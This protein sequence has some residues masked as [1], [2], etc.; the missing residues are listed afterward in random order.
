MSSRAP[1]APHIPL[2][3]RAGEPLSFKITWTYLLLIASRV[4]E[5]LAL[6]TG[7]TLRLVLPTS[8]ATIAANVAN[9][10][11]MRSL[12]SPCGLLLSAFFMWMLVCVPFSIWRGGSVE[13]IRERWLIAYLTF[14]V[15]A[16]LPT[17]LQCRKLFNALVISELIMLGSIQLLGV[18]KQGRLSLNYGTL[19]NANDLAIHLLLGFP[20][21]YFFLLPGR[22][23]SM[24]LRLLLI[25][26]C[27]L[28]ALTIFRTGSRTGLLVLLAVFV[29]VFWRLPAAAKAGVLVAAAV[30]VPLGA[31]FASKT[32]I[33]RFRTLFADKNQID[34]ASMAEATESK[35]ARIDLLIES[36]K[37]TAANPVFGVGPGMFQ[38]AT[39]WRWT[40]GVGM[41][42]RQTHNTYTELSSET[43]IP[44]LLLYVAAMIWCF[45]R[46]SAIQ[47][48]TR[49]YPHLR[50]IHDMAYCLFLSLLTFSLSGPFSSMAYHVHFPMLA[51]IVT[52]FEFALRPLLVKPRVSAARPV[53]M[54]PAMVRV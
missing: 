23:K 40:E 45:R 18:Q 46:L 38:V 42:W 48:A 26:S 21:I 44:G 16:S 34:S 29:I 25:A 13:L 36:L 12:Y 24:F 20:F 32:A 54:R 11:I 6:A 17:V 1:S 39:G 35:D 14:V 51:G 53:S 41:G 50:E 43:G 19:G 47:R 22:T 4:T 2:V 30:L 31:S 3:K 49:D 8:V 7:V 27:I 5:M 52:S 10:G 33:D 9:G 37:L 15:L 28:L